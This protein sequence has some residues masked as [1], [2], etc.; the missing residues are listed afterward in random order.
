MGEEVKEKNEK[1]LTRT[2]EE[3]AAHAHRKADERGAK[4]GDSSVTRCHA[5]LSKK[6]ERGYRKVGK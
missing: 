4:F 3:Y 5:V 1:Q 2:R 6:D